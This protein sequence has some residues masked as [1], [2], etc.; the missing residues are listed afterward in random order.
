MS[1]LYRKYYALIVEK[2]L[3]QEKIRMS[4]LYS[5]PGLQKMQ[6]LDFSQKK[7]PKKKKKNICKYEKKNY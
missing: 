2:E 3:K 6:R 1:F 4:N 5:A 7:T